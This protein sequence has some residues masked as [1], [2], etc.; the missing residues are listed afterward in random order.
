MPSAL[1]HIASAG[2]ASRRAIVDKRGLIIKQADP[3]SGKQTRKSYPTHGL[4]RQQ[5]RGKPPDQ[6]QRPVMSDCRRA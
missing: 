5:G 4:A 1:R 6:S 3:G 2:T